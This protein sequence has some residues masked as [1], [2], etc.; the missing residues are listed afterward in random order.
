MS[1]KTDEA[2]AIV[3]AIIA[4]GEIE[5]NDGQVISGLIRSQQ[6]GNVLLVNS[7][8]KEVTLQEVD[9]DEI[10]QIQTSIMPENFTQVIPEES[11]HDLITYLLSLRTKAE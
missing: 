1:K 11:L 5:K 3:R 10:D 7:E 2:R 8:G 9:I 4:D 6:D